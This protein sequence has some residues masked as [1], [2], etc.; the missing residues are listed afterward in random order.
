VSEVPGQHVPAVGANDWLTIDARELLFRIGNAGPPAAV[1]ARLTSLRDASGDLAGRA[2]VADPQDSRGVVTVG[3][4][5][6]GQL[7]GIDGVLIGTG[8]SI[9]RREAVPVVDAAELARWA[10]DQ[11]R[12]VAQQEEDPWVQCGYAEILAAC[13]ADT[14]DLA[15]AWGPGGWVSARG[16]VAWQAMPDEVWLAALGSVRNLRR[17]EHDLQPQVLVTS[18]GVPDVLRPRSGSPPG[19]G[20]PAP[21]PADPL[22]ADGLNASLYSAAIRAVAQAWRVSLDTLRETSSADDAPNPRGWN[23]RTHKGVPVRAHVLVLRNPR[24]R[25]TA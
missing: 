10:T 3:G 24:V 14:G 11:A 17:E 19:G 20:W 5:R 1:A 13:G 4:L 16:V 9:T 22:L 21:I 6:A 2:S 23:I 25:P 7:Q 12:L 18:V 15:I 8:P